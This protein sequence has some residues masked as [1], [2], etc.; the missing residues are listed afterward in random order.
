MIGNV[1]IGAVVGAT[2]GGALGSTRTC[3][4]GGCPLTSTPKRGALY[5][6]VLG[7]LIAA[8]FV[9]PLP[10]TSLAAETKKPEH[11]K[12]VQSA[13]QFNDEVL[14]TKGKAVVTFS[15]T[16]CSACKVFAPTLDAVA[17]KHAKQASFWK[18]D[19]D[20]VESVAQEYGIRAVPTTIVFTDGKET[21]RFLG[22]VDADRL[23]ESVTGSTS[24]DESG[25]SS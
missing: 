3:G 13:E 11:V 25:T 4:S 7:L 24:K 12:P 8:T 23:G 2:L 9:M 5:G 10:T 1:I 22:I 18:A 19:V 14:G 16:W 15:A 21:A 17:E 20:K 6:G